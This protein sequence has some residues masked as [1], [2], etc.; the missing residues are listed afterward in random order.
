MEDSLQLPTQAFAWIDQ[1][2]LAWLPPALRLVLWSACA[3]ALA[4]LLYGM[5]S[6]QS[7]IVDAKR[8]LA[9]ARADLDGFDGELAD[10][11]PR[12]RRM[13][14]AA[15][16]QLGLVLTPA[17]V[18]LAPMA[19][20]AGW[21]AETYGYAFPDAHDAVPVRTR[22]ERLPA[23]WLPPEPGRDAPRVAVADP[24][25]HWHAEIELQTPVPVI[26]KRSLDAALISSPLGFLPD[27]LPIERI[28]LDLPQR[29]YLDWGPGWMRGW[30]F[31]FFTGLTLVALAIKRAFRIV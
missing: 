22:P 20:L 24:Q 1:Q 21:I 19:L 4:M 2:V 15:F 13:L 8:E 17:L 31:V 11:L 30:E 12:M 9:R 26:R 3:G 29:Q 28:E 18:A 27:E 14:G 23:Q 10:A 5:L 25:G 6:P 16:R 7:R